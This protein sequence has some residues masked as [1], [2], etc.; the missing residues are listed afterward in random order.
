MILYEVF[1]QEISFKNGLAVSYA[2][3]GE[4]YVALGNFSMALTFYE[5]YNQ[6]E[7]AL[8]QAYPQNAE[9]KSNFAE[10]LA[11]LY[12]LQKLMRQAPNDS[13]IDTAIQH[14]EALRALSPAPKYQKKLML[15]QQI[16]VANDDELKRLVTEISA[17]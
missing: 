5:Q 11:I 13:G 3:L 4:T 8:H 12:A 2:K 10:S 15:C 9:F 17:F 1:P 14:Y 6:L 7:E 16:K